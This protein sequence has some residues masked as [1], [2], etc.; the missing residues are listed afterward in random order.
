[1]VRHVKPAA[2]NGGVVRT[3]YRYK[4]LVVATVR[5]GA[6]DVLKLV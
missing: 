3:D 1:M 4:P 6:F 2:S 5:H